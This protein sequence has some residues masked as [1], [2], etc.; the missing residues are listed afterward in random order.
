MV[1]S[2]PCQE[3]EEAF[4]ESKNSTCE[5]L[6]QEGHDTVKEEGTVSGRR[7]VVG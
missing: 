1:R 7:V 6:W 3:W 4:A 5:A 2:L